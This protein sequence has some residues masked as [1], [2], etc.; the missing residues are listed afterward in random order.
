M[1]R[2]ESE[3]LNGSLL[4]EPGKGGGAKLYNVMTIGLKFED[5]VDPVTATYEI[6]RRAGL[7]NPEE[8]RSLASVPEEPMICVPSNK[9]IPTA[10]N[11][12]LEN[13]LPFLNSALIL[14]LCTA[15]FYD[16]TR[17]VI[18]TQTSLTRKIRLFSLGGFYA[19]A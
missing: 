6:L 13:D 14:G 8:L 12:R 5:G 10:H 1:T 3:R 15:T 11:N 17:P 2:R 7:D 16:P 19:S 4:G 18:W 9:V